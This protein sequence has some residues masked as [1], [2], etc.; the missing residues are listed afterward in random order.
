MVWSN[1]ESSVVRSKAVREAL[2][3]GFDRI[4]TSEEILGSVNADPDNDPGFDWVD[5]NDPY[6]RAVA[7]RFI[8]REMAKAVTNRAAE[9]MYDH[10]HLADDGD[11]Y[12]EAAGRILGDAVDTY[13]TV[14]DSYPIREDTDLSISR[15]VRWMDSESEWTPLW[16]IIRKGMEERFDGWK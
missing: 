12:L 2:W 13:M 6:V 15:F 1:I 14:M 16:D 11:A 5:R 8:S 7:Q 10:Y 4:P 3:K 9:S